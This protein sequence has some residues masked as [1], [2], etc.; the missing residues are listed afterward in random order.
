MR[1]QHPL[2]CSQLVVV[3]FFL[4]DCSSIFEIKEKIS[5]ERVSLGS[6]NDTKE[7]EIKRRAQKKKKKKKE[8]ESFFRFFCFP[9]PICCWL[10]A[11]CRSV[12]AIT[13]NSR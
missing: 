9:L 4:F 5:D 1:R 10:A 2:G 12:A 11:C 3:F 13:H 6:E 8:R 7:N